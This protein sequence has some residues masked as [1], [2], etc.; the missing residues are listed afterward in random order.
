MKRRKQVTRAA[1]EQAVDLL[2]EA[3][4][5]LPPLKSAVGGVAFIL[6]QIRLCEDNAAA[7]DQLTLRIVQIGNDLCNCSRLAGGAPDVAERVQHL[8]RFLLDMAQKLEAVRKSGKLSAHALAK[9]EKLV[10]DGC[11]AELN[12]AVVDTN[13]LDTRTL[14]RTTIQDT[15]TSSPTSSRSTRSLNHPN[16]I[17]TPRSWLASEPRGSVALCSVMKYS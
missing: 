2:K 11:W 13:M 14:S 17:V 9:R 4:D 8:V 5:W 1:V 16:R 6:N 12:A 10:L 3:S 15:T 7:C